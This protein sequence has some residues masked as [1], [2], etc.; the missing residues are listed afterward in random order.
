MEAAGPL[1]DQTWFRVVAIP[2]PEPDPE[3]VILE[4]GHEEQDADLTMRYERSEGIVRLTEGEYPDSW[5]RGSISYSIRQPSANAASKAKRKRRRPR[6]PCVHPVEGDVDTALEV[7]VEGDGHGLSVSAWASFHA[8]D[9]PRT[10]PAQ[11][12]PGDRHADGVR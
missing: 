6:D 8:A 7:Q 1:P 12:H 2:S 4:R 5:G 9:D 10:D 3:T 11:R